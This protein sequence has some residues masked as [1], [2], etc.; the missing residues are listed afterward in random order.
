MLWNSPLCA[1][2]ALTHST[3]HAFEALAHSF[4]FRTHSLFTFVSA[5]HPIRNLHTVDIL[6][7]TT[8][9]HFQ[10]HPRYHTYLGE[11]YLVGDIYE[12]VDEENG[13]CP[14]SCDKRPDW[15]LFGKINQNMETVLFREKFIDWPDQSRLIKVKGSDKESESKVTKRNIYINF[16]I[17]AFL[18]N[19]HTINMV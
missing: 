18:G 8:G 14:A 17:I 9:Y 6:L 1:F 3:L 2:E 19:G 16:G 13:G 5:A 4:Y 15:A 11:Q 12:F 7:I 10:F